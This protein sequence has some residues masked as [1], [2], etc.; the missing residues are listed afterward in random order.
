MVKYNNNFINLIKQ[1]KWFLI[2][3]YLLLSF[4]LFITL[5]IINYLKKNNNSYLSKVTDVSFWIYFIINLILILILS[6]IPL[7][8]WARLIIF[9]LLSISIGFFLYQAKKNIPIEYIH[10]TLL[11]TII[12]FI[13]LS[14][15]AVILAFLGYDLGWMNLYILFGIIAL[16]IGYIMLFIFFKETKY[17]K[18]IYK[19][20]IIFGLILFSFNILYST[21]IMLNK[22]YNS[23]F[24]DAAIDLYI[25]I[26]NIFSNLLSLQE[27]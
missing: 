1:K 16:F 5:Y 8:S 9:I 11:S 15:V 13:I 10:Q 2:S 17:D 18:N 4:Q 3:V 24:I 7:P 20:L 19:I 21:N 27:E 22:N 26:I 23:D 25:S 12:L 14:V 6:F